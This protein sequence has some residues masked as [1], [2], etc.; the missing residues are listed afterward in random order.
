M[1]EVDVPRVMSWADEERDLTAWLGNDMQKDAIHALYS[2]SGRVRKLGAPDLLHD[3]ERLQTSD[4]FHYIS[5]KWFAGHLPDR[6]NPFGS[7]YDAYITYMNVL[8]DFE[9]RLT[10]AEHAAALIAAKPR[11]RRSQA[12]AAERKAAPAAKSSPKPAQESAKAGKSPLQ[13]ARGTRKNPSPLQPERLPRADAKPR[14]V[15]G[16]KAAGAASKSLGTSKGAEKK[17]SW[18]RQARALAS[19]T[20]RRM[21]IA[22]RLHRRGLVF[23]SSVRR[24]TAQRQPADGAADERPWPYSAAAWA[25]ACFGRPFEFGRAEV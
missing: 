22:R 15:P 19:P 6:A 11:H 20:N 7:P 2:L 3:F 14:T 4:H 13:P 10:A 1:G 24:E 17:M 16:Q 25:W 5:T 23:R 21:P 9:M 8:A 18:S 12:G